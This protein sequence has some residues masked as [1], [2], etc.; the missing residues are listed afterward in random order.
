ML[1]KARVGLVIGIA[2][3]ILNGLVSGFSGITGP[4]IAIMAGILSGLIVNRSKRP[5]SKKD[6]ARTGALAGGTSGC[7]V[8]L[9]QVIG[10]IVAVF[11]LNSSESIITQAFMG[12]FSIGIALFF[13]G[14]IALFA[15]GVGAVTGSLFANPVSPDMPTG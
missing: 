5:S 13:G 12:I 3:L 15:A 7:V 14:I 4:V 2:G 8:I 9:G 6:A 10:G 1:S 11:S